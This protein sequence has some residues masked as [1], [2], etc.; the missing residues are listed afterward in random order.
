MLPLHAAEAEDEREV[1][2]TAFDNW[3]LKSEHVGGTAVTNGDSNGHTGFPI[4]VLRAISDAL[5]GERPV[6]SGLLRFVAGRLRRYGERAYSVCTTD[7][8][9]GARV[10]Q[11][12]VA[13]ARKGR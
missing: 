3:G 11:N 12:S 4:A 1:R 2:A 9:P 8:R 10:D 7:V 5:D 13:T 6:H